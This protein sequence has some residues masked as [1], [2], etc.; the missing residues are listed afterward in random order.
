MGEVRIG[1]NVSGPWCGLV[2]GRVGVL[3]GILVQ[4]LIVLS[5]FCS[6]GV[7]M[8][9]GWMQKNVSRRD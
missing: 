2:L 4:V 1:S 6:T 7:L 3:M 8:R 9:L 5:R